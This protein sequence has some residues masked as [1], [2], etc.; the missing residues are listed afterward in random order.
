MTN[1]IWAP[2]AHLFAYHLHKTLG[3]EVENPHSLWERCNSILQQLGIPAQLDA[4][5]LSSYQKKEP[6]GNRV[7]LLL[8]AAVG[9]RRSLPFE[10]ET[11]QGVKIKGFVSPLRIGDSY[12]LGFNI[13]I[14]EEDAGKPTE[15]VN[16]AIF[17][18]FNP[19]NCLLPTRTPV[20]NSLG[21]TL[22]ITASLT[23]AQKQEARGKDSQF[24]RKLATE[25]LEKLIPEPENRPAFSRQGKLFGS[26]IFEYSS[27]QGDSSCHI[28]VWLFSHPATSEKFAACYNEIID[29]FFYRNKIVSV[30]Q[31]SR[32][33]SRV[34]R[35][36]Y[37]KIEE[38]IETIFQ[39]LPQSNSSNKGRLSQEN[40]ESLNTELIEMPV[41]A[42]E[43]ARLLRDLQFRHHTI[44]I[45]AGNYADKVATIKERL[46]SDSKYPFEP[47]V[48]FLEAF[49]QE[50][51][52][53]YQ[54]QIVA[55]LGYYGHGSDLLDKAIASIRGIVEIEQARLDREKEDRLQE[56]EER[57]NIEKE[58]EED[59]EKERERNFQIAF[60]AAGFG[61]SVGGIVSS[62]YQLITEERPIFWP[63]PFTQIKWPFSSP[64]PHPFTASVTLGITAGLLAAGFAAWVTKV[65]QNR[66]EKQAQKKQSDS[67]AGS[68]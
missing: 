21:Q 59:R 53:S 27:S 36:E 49:G 5:N 65:W 61:V 43:Y 33:I 17:Q 24:L 14:P 20:N 3:S 31:E 45:N 38:R 8:K 51:C 7:N 30:Y 25:C 10:K 46:A 56:K 11:Q 1:K 12:A 40:L 54:Q 37:E 9:N 60:A 26:D 2:N 50:T 22:L 35:S 32:K 48:P 66:L 18:E 44:E 6:A 16:T 13:R 67:T 47:A 4:S 62:G 52:T 58:K 68:K 29:L 39:G 64:P 57:D 63:L 15:P 41:R 42:V 23:V 55:D 28:L 34:T 19:N